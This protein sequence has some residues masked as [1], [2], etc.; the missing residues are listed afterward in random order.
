MK[1]VLH[2]EETLDVFEE[3]IELKR[4]YLIVVIYDISDNK[5]RGKLSKLLKSY[6]FRVQKSAFECYLRLNIYNKLMKEID[7]YVKIG[8]LIRVYKLSGRA[9]VTIYGDYIENPDEEE[10]IIV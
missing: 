3:E 9:D 4:K 6:G 1:E 2:F 10:I 8:D 7:K 5:R